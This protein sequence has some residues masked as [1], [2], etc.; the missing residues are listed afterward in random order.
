MI[1][2]RACAWPPERLAEAL[3]T[4]ARAMGV[5][6][7]FAAHGD[8]GPRSTDEEP[9]DRW[10][11]DACAHLGLEL[12]HGNLA[13]AAVDRAL[14]KL[15]PALVRVDAGFLAVVRCG[16]DAELALPDGSRRRM[17]LAALRGVLVGPLE[18][19]ALP[20]IDRLVERHAL[21]PRAGVALLREQ[22]QAA[23]VRGFWQFDRPAAGSVWTEA[24]SA[25][26]PR[27]LV[28]LV[29]ALALQY[30]LLLAAWGVIGRAALLGRFDIGWFAAWLLLLATQVPISA[31]VLWLQGVIT[32]AAGATLKRRLLLGAMRLAP[33]EI[34]SQGVGQLLGRV[35]EAVNLEGRLL[36][37][38]LTALTVV[39]EIAMGVALLV[40]VGSVFCA[41]LLVTFSGLTVLLAR[42]EVVAMRA[43]SRTQ[44]DLTH[45]VVERMIGYRTRLAQEPQ[46]GWHAAEE[47][48]IR[49]YWDASRRLDRI[50]IPIMNL[51][52]FWLVIGMLAVLPAFVAGDR[53]LVSFAATIGV[54][55]LA[56]RSF[57]KSSLA[58]VQLAGAVVAWGHVRTLF[59][60]ATRV[61]P[62]GPPMH[63][64]IA[65]RI[66]VVEGHE[67]VF[68]YRPNGPAVLDECSLAIAH[69]DRVLLE[70]ASGSGKSTLA[71]VLAGLRAP[72]AGLLASRGLDVHTIGRP[73]WRARIVAVPQFHENHVFCGS[74]AFN[75]LLGKQWPP[76]QHDLEAARTICEELGLGPLLAR[77]PS[78]LDEMVGDSGW[79][80]SHGERTRL[81]IARALLQGGDLVVLD[82][83]F[84]ALDPDSFAAAMDTVVRRAPSLL[85][86]AHR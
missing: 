51:G 76:S 84:A 85:V 6:A 17:S 22:L 35:L 49:R 46:A 32:V 63:Q 67:L 75:L 26:I 62:A 61:V 52:R 36:L 68:R 64:P 83:S 39:V 70:G 18:A 24:R 2:V 65:E 34:R 55:V 42:R 41:V 50:E 14:P 45:D 12:E 28:Q 33:E 80:L 19:G 53:S 54:V 48:A 74:V 47:A 10:L 43:W 4:I 30:A 73:A 57:R 40:A 78:G 38:A 82:E 86:I 56:Y 37:G 27:R 16:R 7:T 72:E 79:Q 21:H 69:G 44:L 59:R 15:A 77:M 58:V 11:T 20:A 13:Y 71:S 29:A 9:V 66:P 1:D 3:E 23:R 31:V 81:F 25:G 60:A 8:T 5:T